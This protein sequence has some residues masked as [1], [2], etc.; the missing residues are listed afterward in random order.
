MRY[1]GYG[2]RGFEFDYLNVQSYELEIYVRD[3]MFTSKEENLTVNITWKNQPP[4]FD[5]HMYSSS[6]FEMAVS[7]IS[8]ISSL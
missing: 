5:V 8:N 4:V 6:V 3:D 7:D 1:I 2:I